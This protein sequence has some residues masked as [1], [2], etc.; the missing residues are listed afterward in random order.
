LKA[1]SENKNLDFRSVIRQEF[2][3]SP[4]YSPVDGEKIKTLTK[5]GRIFTG[6]HSAKWWLITKNNRYS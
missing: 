6:I 2:Q 5:V 4:D 1:L 3:K